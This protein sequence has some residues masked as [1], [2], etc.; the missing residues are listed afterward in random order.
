MITFV[1]NHVKLYSLCA[2]T[3]KRWTI[4]R[5]SHYKMCKG[6]IKSCSLCYYYYRIHEISYPRSK[7]CLS[8][9]LFQSHVQTAGQI[10]I[11]CLGLCSYCKTCLSLK[12]N[13]YK[14]CP[15]S[16]GTPW[17][18][19]VVQW[20]FRHDVDIAGVP[21]AL[22]R[23]QLNIFNSV[24][25]FTP[26]HYRYATSFDKITVK[27]FQHVKMPTFPHHHHIFALTYTT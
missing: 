17:M 20:L 8:Y 13:L 19:N 25:K 12:R 26:P 23:Y 16:Y 6:M 22:T 4:L 24:K 9:E 18:Y 11:S 2:W 15:E 7:L 27:H 3:M 14:A 5:N 10:F 1:R 21:R